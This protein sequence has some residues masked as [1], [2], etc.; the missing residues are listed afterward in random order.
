MLNPDLVAQRYHEHLAKQAEKLKNQPD[1][2]QLKK[3]EEISR[4]IVAQKVQ[5]A[6]NRQIHTAKKKEY[7]CEVCNHIIPIGTKYRRQTLVTGYGFPEGNHYETKITHVG[8][9]GGK[10]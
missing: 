6:R 1:Y 5:D 2:E 4:A 9:V 10:A 3:E 8:C 7:L